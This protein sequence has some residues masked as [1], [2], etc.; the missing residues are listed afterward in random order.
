MNSIGHQIIRLS[1]VGSTNNYA[2]NLLRTENV[3][4]GTVILALNQSSGR[5]QMQNSWVSEAGANLTLSVV[6]RPVF[7]NVTH[8]FALSQLVSIAL[9]ETL[10]NVGVTEVAVKWP[11]DILIHNKKVAGVLVE[12]TLVGKQ[13]ASSVI[14]IGLN[15]NQQDFKQLPY[16][17]SIAKEAGEKMDLEHVLSQLLQQ[18]NLW[19]MKLQL[20]KFEELKSTYMECLVG[21]KKPLLYFVGNTPELL[22]IVD[23]EQSGRVVVMDKDKK[24]SSFNFQELKLDYSYLANQ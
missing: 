3:S 4:E 16:A 2:A 19:Y 17:T 21:V 12:N 11:N 15:V 23:V 7:L 8:Q 20:K 10:K 9:A 13:I 14:G 18:L 6:L 22:E 1:S 5:G 24:M